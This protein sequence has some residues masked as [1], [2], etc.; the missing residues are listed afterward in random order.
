MFLADDE[1]L[2][3]DAMADS[4]YHRCFDPLGGLEFDIEAYAAWTDS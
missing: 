3:G 2:L 1:K 4:D